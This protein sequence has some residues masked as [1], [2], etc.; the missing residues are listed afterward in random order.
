M[1]KIRTGQMEAFENAQEQR[2]IGEFLAY[3]EAFGLENHIPTNHVGRDAVRAGMARASR[4]GLSTKD[5]LTAF[6]LTDMLVCQ[7]FADFPCV[8]EMLQDSSQPPSQR[9]TNVLTGLD[10]E[11]WEI[12]AAHRNQ[13]VV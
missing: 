8:E 9:L 4:H 1:L 13:E 12:V 7:G 2:F 3:L 5:Q 6:L 11:D 10:D